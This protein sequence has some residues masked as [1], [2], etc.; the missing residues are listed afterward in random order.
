M[1]RSGILFIL[2][3]VLMSAGFFLS[4][5]LDAWAAINQV[6]GPERLG[7][8]DRYLT[9][10]STDKPIYRVGETL[11]VRAVFLN[12][13]DNTPIEEPEY[14]VKVQIKGPRGDVVYTGMSQTRHS[15]AGIS[16][17]I[18][19]TLS[20]GQYQVS[21]KGEHLG[22]P[23]AERTI[24]IRAYRPPR[25]KTRIEFLRDGYGAGDQVKV[26]A[27]ILRA[28]GGVP[29]KATVTVIARV[30]GQEVFRK[31]GFRVSAQGTVGASFNLPDEIQ[32]GD[33]L[34][35]LIIEDGGVKET[36]SKS[37]PIL[38][39]SLDIEF[40]PEGGDLIAGLS[41][42]VYLQARQKNGKPA[43]VQGYLV[44]MN[45]DNPA[46]PGLAVPGPAVPGPAVPEKIK[47]RTEHEGRGL[48]EFRPEADKQYALK[49]EKPSGI[50]RLFPL[51]R[52]K[53]AGVVLRAAKPVYEFDDSITAYIQA[54]HPRQ[55]G[56]VTLYKRDKLLD[57]QEPVQDQKGLMAT[58]DA[59]DSEGVLMVTVWDKAGNP[60]AERLIFRKPR[61]RI[62]LEIETRKASFTPG[63][64][65]TMQLR[66]TDENGNPV[67]AVVG[68][69]VTDDSVLQMLEQRDLPPALPV[70]VYLE[71][72]VLDLADAEVYFNSDNPD[73][74]RDIDYL[75]GI[76]GWRRFIL[77][78]YD[79]IKQQYG[80]RGQRVM[81][82]NVRAVPMPMARGGV[83]PLFE[84]VRPL[85]AMPPRVVKQQQMPVFEKVQ[86]PVLAEDMLLAEEAV[87][88][89]RAMFK[90]KPGHVAVR[91][92][93]HERAADRRPNDRSDFT[94]TLYW[95]AG[96]RTNPRDGTATVSFDLS[97][98]VTSFRV[99]ADGFGRNG[100]LGASQSMIESVEPFYI[101]AKWP[102]QAT[103]GD[104]VE[105]PVV[106]V[107]ATDEDLGEARL[108][109]KS[110]LSM[111]APRQVRLRPHSRVRQI[112][113]FKVSNPGIHDVQ[114]LAA[115]GSFADSVHHKLEVKPKGFP[116]A[117][118][119]GGLVGPDKPVAMNL[120]LPEQVEPGSLTALA[121]VYPSPVANM[122]D[123]LNALLRAP[124]GCFEQTSSTNYPL[125][126]A[127]HYYLTHTG[128]DPEKIARAKQ[129]LEA[130]YQRLT[131]F[132]SQGNG[133]EWFGADPAHEALTAY[134]LMQFHDMAELM[135]IDGDMMKRT[136]SWLLSR[137]DGRGGFLKNEKAL[138]SFGRAPTPTTN[139]YI[140]WALLEAGESPTTLSK[141]IQSVKQQ[142]STSHD[143][144]LIALAANIMYL[145]NDFVA[146]T[147]FSEKLANAM[148]Q[149]GAVKSAVTSITLSG[150]VSLTIETTSLSVLA[151]LKDDDRW[152]D[153][154]EK[155]MKWLFESTQS[156]RFGST[157]ATV[158]AL[159]AIN[160]YDQAR[161]KPE[162]PGS[163]QLY[164]NGKPFGKAVHF[165]QDAR[166]AIELPEFS[167]ALSSGQQTI[168]IRM[169]D[170]SQMPFALT[171]NYATSLPVS[172]ATAPVR[173][174][175]QW[176]ARRPLEGEPVEL[177][178]TLM[179]GQEAVSMPVAVIG[180]PAGLEVR[181]QQLKEWV[182]AGRI[183]AYEVMGKN[184]VLYWRGFKPQ[185]TTTLAISFIAEIPGTYTGA[186]SRSYPYYAEENAYWTK[187]ETVV[188]LPRE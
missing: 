66:A 54:S 70:M 16:W 77:V 122:E 18:P 119:K 71:N 45:S 69:S 141:E 67:E 43:E 115:A 20:A 109:V 59:Q 152:A 79:Q 156:G 85:A 186:A 185:E 99:R 159:K 103:A 130:G 1:K 55:I 167:A 178:V 5:M 187:G 148:D 117:I 47:V 28:E 60:L 58:L 82:E 35:S 10:V 170:G 8:K 7:G 93:A 111:K 32:A 90:R 173:L 22:T 155:A 120:S 126:M 21:V 147:E 153:R 44:E 131:G 132:E 65:V 27:R 83:V 48:F 50:D 49:L 42:R 101:S 76:Q 158:L 72:E 174:T 6:I 113:T 134:G 142:A 53:N 80:V 169:T 95:N 175:T 19:D 3:L 171:V 4:P 145:A 25:L 162:K 88:A 100:A 176:S 149:D 154:V 143:S 128:S 133:Y 112:L 94:E 37:I 144:Y 51:P 26:S 135:E 97:D 106:L 2:A 166:E 182:G 161:S 179:A 31:S 168:E 14:S 164:V 38:T 180:I 124:H 23:E 137:R 123:A 68:V 136:R 127:Q 11:Y 108:Q 12:A 92:Y 110:P 15:T 129:L 107:N 39:H 9:Y 17:T 139:A 104:T 33:G 157:Q 118:H 138:D 40:F 57:S 86:A 84:E 13:A 78:N 105:L 74:D 29:D 46:V 87:A 36:A 188:V 146:A 96:I 41:S 102:L 34:L 151:W 114:L 89:D 150:G 81:A 61:F 184:L 24:E 181:H 116:V 52:V 165:D 163:L 140:V 91:E 172:R 63:S 64:K 62:N 75:L 177:V 73:A 183:S 160:A 121:K 30:D 98:S 125:V 56:R